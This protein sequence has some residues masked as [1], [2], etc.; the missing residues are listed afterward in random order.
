[1]FPKFYRSPYLSRKESY[2]DT[3]EEHDPIS[4]ASDAGISELHSEALP[5]VE[6]IPSSSAEPEKKIQRQET[7]GRKAAR[8]VDGLDIDDMINELIQ[9]SSKV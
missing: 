4:E 9:V 3:D 1:M 8:L 5:V 2:R 6:A 7:I